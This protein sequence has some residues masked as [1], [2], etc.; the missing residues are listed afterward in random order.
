MDRRTFLSS[1]TLGAALV[2]VPLGTAAAASCREAAPVK[3]LAELQAAIDKAAAGAVITL[4]NGDYTVP[5]G[6]PITVKGRRGTEAQ[7]ITIVAESRGGV[8]LRGE[9]SFV[10]S[11][12]SFI[13]ISGFSLRQSTTLDV[14][15][16]CS[17]IRLTRND[18]QFA[19]ISELNWVM[20]RADDSKVDRNHFHG[21]T[22]QGI[23]LGIE[24]AG[25][26]GM[27]QNVQVFRNYFS[28]HSFAGDNGGE[29][30]RLGLSPRALTK[31][32]AKVEYNLFER[33]NGDPE[34]ISIKS[35]GNF[36]RHN[37]IRDSKGGIVLR[38]GNGT[39]VEAN[40]LL[41][42]QEGVRIYGNDHV[43]VNNYVA[44]ITGRGLVV[45]SG[46]ERDHT[47]GE[48]D[49][50]RRG[51]D[52]AD[53]VL[54]ANNTLLNNKSTLSGET[55]RP[56]EPH[57]CVIAD[58]LLIGDT[59]DLVSMGNTVGFRW[60]GNIV[61]GA[62]TD[63]N[64]PAAGYRRV[65]PRLARGADGVSRLTASSPAIGAATLSPAPVTEDIDGQPRGSARDVG[66]DEYSSAAP[67]LR[68]L[69]PADVG[70]A[71]P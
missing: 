70:P 64:A 28:D 69:T 17:A 20:V 19:D 33:A 4:K 14:P 57:D 39:R 37:T 51:N 7:P 63:G 50:T 13:T 54:I 42:G 34:A 31:A 16:D 6:K 12:S 52:A 35:S 56:F 8:V 15:P 29:P 60:S 59:G 71:A 21:K 18:L 43:V 10:F 1:A 41:G 66:A 68:P 48:P 5:T 65:D 55:N 2:V 45:G 24:G 11:S 26:D 22:T 9:Q 23:F 62:G 36:V 61:F 58:N 3:S 44:G 40:Y 49:D 53:R 32:G 30:I 46:S 27:A 25:K 47:P 67:L 38:H